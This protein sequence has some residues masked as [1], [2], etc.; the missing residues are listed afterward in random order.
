[1]NLELKNKSLEKQKIV[2]IINPKSG[3]AK[4]ENIGNQIIMHL[5]KERY[6]YKIAYTEY[7]GHAI[8]L[9]KQYVENG[10]E[11]V[12]A[13]GGDGSVNEIVNGLKGSK[14]KLGI[15]PLG[16]GNGLARFLKIPLLIKEAIEVINRDKFIAIDTVNVNDTVFVSIAGIGF[17][18][19]V[20]KRFA[21]YHK[22]GFWS[23]LTIATKEYRMY[24]PR[25]YKITINGELIT[26]RALMVVFAN[27]DQFGYNTSIAPQASIEDGL[28]DVCIVKKVPVYKMFF[29]IHLLFLKQLNK[30]KY[31]EIIKAEEVFIS[32]KR[33]KVVNIDGDPVKISKQLHIKVN[34]LALN[35][36]IP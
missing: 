26:R 30:T 22:R 29:F 17:D 31:L 2:F 20:A 32:R 9:T 14:V 16:S 28:V 36:I 23:Y 11:I 5:D 33:N 34:H 35:V 6:D 15:I 18:A 4:K 3:I 12:V 27:S 1:L 21:K 24:R 7:A 10:T 25:K 19:L 8:E 13:V